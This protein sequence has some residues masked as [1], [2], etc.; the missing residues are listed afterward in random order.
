MV[1]SVPEFTMRTISIV[2]TSSV[3]SCAILTSISVGAP[4][5]RPRCAASITASRIAGWLCPSTIGPQE[6][7]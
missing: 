6:P 3:T 4:K 2:G 5:L 1:A 7:T